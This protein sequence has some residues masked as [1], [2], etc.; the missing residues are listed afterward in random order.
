MEEGFSLN[1][2][3]LQEYQP[4][5]F[6]IDFDNA[7]VAREGDVGGDDQIIAAARFQLDELHVAAGIAQ[8]ELRNR[9]MPA[10]G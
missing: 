3:E 1:A 5:S 8:R 7:A 6:R 4:N 9:S 2:I 10:R